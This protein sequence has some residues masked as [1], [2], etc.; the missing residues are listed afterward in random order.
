MRFFIELSYKGTNYHGW[1]AQANAG[2][3]QQKTEEAFF[4][5]MRNR[6]RLTGA[7][8]TDTGVHAS[9]YT[10]HFDAG[11]PIL[12]T[13]AYKLNRVLPPDIN[14]YN[15]TQVPEDSHARFDA[16]SR[17]YRYVLTSRKHPFARELA[18][19]LPKLPDPGILNHASAMLKGCHDFTTFSKL[20]S[21]NKTNMCRIDDATWVTRKDFLIFTITADRFLRN[22]VRSITGT[23]LDAGRGKISVEEFGLI[24]HGCD[25]S[26]AA[27]SAPPEG[28]YL[29]DIRYPETYGLCNRGKDEILPFAW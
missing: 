27:T 21:N 3:I 13:L 12:P 7:G 19:F 9:Y 23:L 29:T 11:K 1:Q 18:A 16:L 10:A 5:V 26:R 17:T 20:H 28:L 25:R 6:I 2:S 14:I 15:I 24:F 22:M 8:R 4:T